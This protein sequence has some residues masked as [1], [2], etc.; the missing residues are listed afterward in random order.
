MTVR[1]Y[2]EQLIRQLKEAGAFG[3]A[4]I[5]VQLDAEGRVATNTATPPSVHVELEVAL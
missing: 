1:D 4:K 3:V 5:Y 2:I